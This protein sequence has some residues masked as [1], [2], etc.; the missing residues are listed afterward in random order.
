MMLHLRLSKVL[1]ITLCNFV[2]FCLL[3]FCVYLFIISRE[4]SIDLVLLDWSCVSKDLL[5]N[6]VSSV[7]KF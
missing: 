2:W 4:F 5:T 7:P 1:E 3:S 6:P